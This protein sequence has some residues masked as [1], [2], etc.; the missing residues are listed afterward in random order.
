M[1]CFEESKGERKLFRDSEII[2]QIYN[3]CQI[4]VSLVHYFTAQI[5]IK[6]T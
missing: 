1:I 6:G 3:S 5:V 4:S 2:D